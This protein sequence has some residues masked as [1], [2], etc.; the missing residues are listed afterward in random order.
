[1]KKDSFLLN[2]ILGV[3]LMILLAVAA[4]SQNNSNSHNKINTAIT[5]KKKTISAGEGRILYVEKYG[6]QPSDKRKS[7]SRNDINDIIP[8]E[9]VSTKKD[10]SPE[11]TFTIRN[12]NPAEVKELKQPKALYKGPVK[13]P[14]E[15]NVAKPSPAEI[16]QPAF[17]EHIEINISPG[18]D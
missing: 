9:T 1:M 11:A 14:A 16:R 6:K 4:K 2:F 3:I 10:S 8:D 12:Q 7:Y 18:S 5:K 15:M 13:N 17:L